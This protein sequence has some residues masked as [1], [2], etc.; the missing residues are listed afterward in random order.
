MISYD[1]TSEK[2]ETELSHAPPPFP[3]YGYKTSQEAG[4]E[5]S[6]HAT[7]KDIHQ[8]QSG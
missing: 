4:A 1:F 7:K 8:T 2:L 5:R 3:L 6:S